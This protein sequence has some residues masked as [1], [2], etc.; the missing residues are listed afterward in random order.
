MGCGQD[1]MYCCSDLG[2]NSHFLRVC[3]DRR[4]PRTCSVEFHRENINFASKLH[5]LHVCGDRR[6]PRICPVEFHHAK[7]N[8]VS[9]ICL[10]RVCGDRRSPQT[11][12]VFCCNTRLRGDTST[13][14]STIPT[15]LSVYFTLYFVAILKYVGIVN[16]H[17]FIN[18]F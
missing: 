9:N 16:S 13:W 14:G 6:S 10:V 17:A 18:T 12:S 5:L 11:C 3:G 15:Y 8:F 7:I 4:S 2:H 1:G